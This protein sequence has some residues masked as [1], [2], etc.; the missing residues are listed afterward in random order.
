MCD[1]DN[2]CQ[3]T[4]PGGGLC[5]QCQ[6]EQKWEQG[7]P[8]A[9]DGEYTPECFSCESIVEHIE[10]HPR[11]PGAVLCEDCH[12][13]VNEDRDAVADGGV[14]PATTTVEL[15]TEA[16]RRTI[17]IERQALATPSATV[18]QARKCAGVDVDEFNG[19]RVR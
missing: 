11:K 10:Y 6:V 5:S 3:K 2:G 14:E 12:R 4:T 7:D 15:Q 16:G 13:E 9:L 19:G 17:E 1:S 8:H 18:D